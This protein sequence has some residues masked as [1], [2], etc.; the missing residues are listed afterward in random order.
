MPEEGTAPE[1]ETETGDTPTQPK[2]TETVDFWK[3]KAREQEK[4]AR[5]NASARAE[6]DELREANLSKEE[7]LQRERDDALTQVAQVRAEALRWK[8]AAKHGITDEDAELFL[9]GT[10]ETT[11]TRQAERLSAR[12]RDEKPDGLYVPQEG[13]QPSPP[14]LNSDDLEAALKA[15]LGI[16]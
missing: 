6:L 5:E 3:A 2:P 16:A 7:K 13:R 9:T 11:L 8:I 12:M 14:A 10:D 1:S 4:K 15:K